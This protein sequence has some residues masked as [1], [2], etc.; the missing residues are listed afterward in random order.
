[1]DIDITTFEGYAMADVANKGDEVQEVTIHR[2][3]RVVLSPE[4][5]LRRMES[6]TERKEKIIAAVRKGKTRDIPS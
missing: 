4:E 3:K 6:I 2:P 5:S 1:M